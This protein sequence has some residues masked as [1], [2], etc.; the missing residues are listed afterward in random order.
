MRT[1]TIINAIILL[2]FIMLIGFT[3]TFTMDMFPTNGRTFKENINKKSYQTY[4][5]LSV[6]GLT[7]LADLYGI[8]TIYR[9]NRTPLSQF[10]KNK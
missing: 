3:L 10:C 8:Y 1:L 9:I 5:L 4:I 6:I 2:N 7:I